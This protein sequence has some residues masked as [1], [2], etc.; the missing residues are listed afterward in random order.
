MKRGIGKFSA[1]LILL[2]GQQVMAIQQEAR[3]A[4]DPSVFDNSVEKLREEAGTPGLAAGVL[5]DGQLLRLKGYGVAGSDGQPVTAQ[6]AFQIGSITKSFVALV[7]LQMASEG[8]LELD[9][10]VVRHVPAFR[11]ASKTQSHQITIHHLVTHRSGLT[12]LDGN[13]LK[14][15]EPGSSGPE[16]AVAGL[17]DVQLFAEPGTTF[18]YS[19][20]NYVLL[21][22]LIE[23]LDER[24]FERSLQARIF[25]PLSMTNSFVSVPPSNKISLAN[26]YRLW[27]GVARAWHPEADTVADRRMIGAGGIWTSIEDLAHYV[28]AVH[29]R[30]PRIV[31]VGADRLFAI[32]LFDKEVGYAYGWFADGT[33]GE[34]VFEHSGFTPGF[35]TLATIVPATGEVVVVLTNMSGLGQGDLP[36]AVTHAAL[37]WEPISA[38]PALGARIAIWSA[39]SA[40]LGLVL[41]LY[42]TGHSLFF[43]R[44]PMRPWV[45]ALNVGV[46]LGLIAGVYVVFVGFQAMVGVSFETGFAFYPDFTLTTVVTMALALVLAV[47][48]LLLV[49]R[50]G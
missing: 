41:L 36:R 29:T 45:R 21:S 44:Q 22:H 28:E 20:A 9:D 14:A 47:G 23:V 11:T 38:A 40:P 34:T 48:R 6:T 3:S 49:I 26:G 8:K 32:E 46:V 17:A 35:L 15:E 10:P 31:P 50:S 19:N 39:V 4:F 24:T 25:T 42:R 30:D 12:T 33:G 43:R 18:Q 1:L 16:A 7:I 27:F 13:S 5:R 2:A 37:G